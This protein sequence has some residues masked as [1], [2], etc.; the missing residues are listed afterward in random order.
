MAEKTINK[1]TIHCQSKGMFN[2]VACIVK[3]NWHVDHAHRMK[4]SY[5]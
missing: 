5:S 2:R 1:V 3:Q 4:N